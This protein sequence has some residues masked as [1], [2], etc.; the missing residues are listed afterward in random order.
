MLTIQTMPMTTSMMLR[1][2][3]TSTTLG[4][5]RAKRGD[6][7][8]H[9]GSPEKEASRKSKRVLVLGMVKVLSLE[10]MSE[11]GGRHMKVVG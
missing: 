10:L 11:E 5:W 7:R 9:F 4:A 2:A 3:R 1:S 8:P 6:A